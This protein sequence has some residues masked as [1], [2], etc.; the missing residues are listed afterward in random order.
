MEQKDNTISSTNTS[1]DK[2]NENNDTINLLIIGNG[3]DL[4]HGMPTRYV[5]FLYFIGQLIIKYDLYDCQ[6]DSNP[7]ERDLTNVRECIRIY[8][9]DFPC[10]TKVINKISKTI[11]NNEY[12]M[13]SISENDWLK[14]FFFTYR[15]ALNDK[16]NWVDFETELFKALIYIDKSFEV[17]KLKDGFQ[18]SHYGLQLENSKNGLLYHKIVSYS[19]FVRKNNIDEE[20]FNCVTSADTAGINDFLKEQLFNYLYEQLIDL[21]KILT[22]YLSKIEEPQWIPAMAIT[23]VDILLSFNYTKTF[24]NLYPKL[25]KNL[26]EYDFINGSLDKNIIL[27][28]DSSNTQTIKQYCDN[29]IYKFFKYIQR[30]EFNFNQKWPIWIKDTPIIP[31]KKEI[32]TMIIGHSLDITDKHVLYNVITKSTK[33]DIYYWNKNDRISKIKNLLKLLGEDLF[34]SAVNNPANK[35]YIQLIDQ[36]KIMI[37]PIENN[38]E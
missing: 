38:K 29:N 15:A 27:G 17:Y 32:H 25:T 13:K 34:Q 23:N 4:A 33:V 9:H 7:D 37:N 3:F 24:L 31:G 22:Y 5:D 1:N 14:Y 35:P 11:H 12:F 30:V 21:S 18:I 26:V 36:N 16:N 2:T 10:R 20:L 19:N 8:E 6:Y 28:I